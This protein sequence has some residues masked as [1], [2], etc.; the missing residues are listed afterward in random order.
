MIGYATMIAM[1][2]ADVRGPL[3]ARHDDPQLRH[4]ARMFVEN[5]GN[6][7]PQWAMDAAI[8][9]WVEASCPDPVPGRASC[10]YCGYF[11]VEAPAAEPDPSTLEAPAGDV[12]R[13]ER[14]D[15]TFGST[16]DT[17][18]DKVVMLRGYGTIPGM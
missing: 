17:D 18:P 5:T 4:H 11:L 3:R 7:C 6:C 13:C 10:P 1:L 16:W 9:M 12:G 14:C 2:P 8:A 15:H